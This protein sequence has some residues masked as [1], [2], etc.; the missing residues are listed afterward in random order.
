MVWEGGSWQGWA[1]VEGICSSRAGEQAPGPRQH[2]R[3]SRPPK[4]RA[5]NTRVCDTG[6]SSPEERCAPGP[7]SQGDHTAAAVPVTLSLRADVSEH[8]KPVSQ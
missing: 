4:F 8:N 3:S 7:G 2:P 5:L 6:K 1:L